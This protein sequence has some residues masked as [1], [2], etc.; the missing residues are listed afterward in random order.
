MEK[1]LSH[2]ASMP[3]RSAASFHIKYA[4]DARSQYF[5][6]LRVDEF[7]IAA[8]PGDQFTDPR[9][10]GSLIRISSWMIRFCA[11]CSSRIIPVLP[12]LRVSRPGVVEIDS[13]MVTQCQLHV[14]GEGNRKRISLP[15]LLLGS[16]VLLWCLHWYI[17]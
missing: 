6:I 4:A 16:S 2:L 5:C 8:F 7:V 17:V 13:A 15:C 1:P 12:S 11:K 14:T 3:W 10:V 9:A